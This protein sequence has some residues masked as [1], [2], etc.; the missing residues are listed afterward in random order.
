MLF[1]A[2]AFSKIKKIALNLPKVDRSDDA[3]FDRA[4]FVITARKNVCLP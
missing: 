1:C 3:T 2:P 4:P